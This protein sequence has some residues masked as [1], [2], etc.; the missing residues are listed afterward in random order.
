ML[1]KAQGVAPEFFHVVTPN[2]AHPIHAFRV[3]DYAAYFRL[4]RNQL[5]ATVRIAR[6]LPSSQRVGAST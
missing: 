1:T 5:A 2:L 6:P 3:D 4:V